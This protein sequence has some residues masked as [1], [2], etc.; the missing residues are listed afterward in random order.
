MKKEKEDW[1]RLYH[2]T[3]K[4]IEIMIDVQRIVKDIKRMAKEANTMITEME[5]S[6]LMVSINITKNAMNI[7]QISEY[8]QYLVQSNIDKQMFQTQ[9]MLANKLDYYKEKGSKY[10]DDNIW[11]IQEL[12]MDEETKK[13]EGKVEDEEVILIKLY[14]VSTTT[15]LLLTSFITDEVKNLF[16]YMKF[17]QSPTQ[18]RL[19]KPPLHYQSLKSRGEQDPIFWKEVATAFV[20]QKHNTETARNGYQIPMFQGGPPHEPYFIA[21]NNREQIIIGPSKKI[22]ATHV[23]GELEVLI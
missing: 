19:F 14:K 1:T 16:K 18:T 20:D 7:A 17:V 9:R 12:Y 13:K 6:I 22:V 11:E 23:V 21:I 2:K 4:G 10:M 8:L 15:S 5:R 3:L